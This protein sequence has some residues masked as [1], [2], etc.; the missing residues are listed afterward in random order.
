QV[1][2]D[3]FFAVRVTGEEDVVSRLSQIHTAIYRPLVDAIVITGND[4]GGATEPS[5]FRQAPLNWLLRHSGA[6][7]EVARDQYEVDIEFLGR[8]DDRSQ[9]VHR[10]LVAG[11]MDV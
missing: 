8:R 7:K 9:G 6:V 10:V 4:D 2:E 1:L 5:Q 3:Q 11:D